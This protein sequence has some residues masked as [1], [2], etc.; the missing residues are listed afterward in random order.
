M[1][2]GVSPDNAR[3]ILLD[4]AMPGGVKLLFISID[5]GEDGGHEQG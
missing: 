2:A 5:H 1:R 3:G 4:D